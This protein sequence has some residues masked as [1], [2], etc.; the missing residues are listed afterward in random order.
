MRK[1]AFWLLFILLS[2]ASCYERP[3]LAV[4]PAISFNDFYFRD[5]P[6]FSLDSMVL[7]INFED[8]DGDLGLESWETDPP[9]HLFDIF[10]FNGDTL[11]LG[12]NDTLP[13][14]NCVDYE[15]IVNGGRPDTVYVRRNPNHFNFFL[16]FLVKDG[17]SFRPFDPARERNCAPPYNGR[18]FVLNT[19]RTLR[20]LR[21]QLQYRLVSGFRL[22]FRNDSIK[23]GVQIQDRSLN[24]SN[25]LETDAFMIQDRFRGF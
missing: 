5:I 21:G 25:Y 6:N 3:E 4:V 20:P 22:L 23:I 7:I 11:K 18:Y 8:G 15:I 17:D 2:Y 9:Y 10:V 14:F 13:P 24:R 16:T 19:S 12:D 1:S